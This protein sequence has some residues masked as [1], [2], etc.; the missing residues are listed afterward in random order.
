MKARQEIIGIE[1]AVQ[2]DYNVQMCN[3]RN[4]TKTKPYNRT[5]PTTQ[6]NHRNNLVEFRNISSRFT[7]FNTG[8][9]TT[10]K[11]IAL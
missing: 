10:V 1:R 8:N 6:T 2:H 7:D 4:S 11:T 3:K 9:K 5:P